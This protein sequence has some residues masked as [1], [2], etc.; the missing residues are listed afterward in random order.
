MQHI[1]SSWHSVHG[2]NSHHTSTKMRT[3]FILLVVVA[4]ASCQ[5][6]A[7][8]I[9]D[10]LS[11][12]EL[13]DLIADKRRVTFNINCLLAEPT[14]QQCFQDPLQNP[15]QN[16]VRDFAS[17]RVICKHCSGTQRRKVGFILSR[18][19]QDYTDDYNKLSKKFGFA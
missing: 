7:L 9:I 10:S 6:T 8:G 17:D 14:P 16:A 15:L 4:A 1:P 13:R 19:Q 12:D 11:L 18:L 5:N 2:I 3:L